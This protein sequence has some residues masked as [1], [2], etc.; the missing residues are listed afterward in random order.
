[1]ADALAGRAITCPSC[2]RNIQ[3]KADSSVAQSLGIV[4]LAMR[5]LRRTIERFRR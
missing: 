3:L 1:M 2:H 5:D 4:D